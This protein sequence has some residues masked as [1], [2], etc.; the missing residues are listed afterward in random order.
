MKLWKLIVLT[1]GLVGLG[2]GGWK[3]TAPGKET[4]D[5][6]PGKVLRSRVIRDAKLAAKPGTPAGYFRCAY[7]SL[8]EAYGK[9]VRQMEK[10]TGIACRKL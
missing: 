4:H 9:A 2:F 10:T 3:L 8:A 6:K 5:E 7:R 1:L